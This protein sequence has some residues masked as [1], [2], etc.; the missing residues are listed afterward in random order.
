[1]NDVY[2]VKNIIPYSLFYRKDFSLDMF[3]HHSEWKLLKEL[4]I[5]KIP[6]NY[7]W[8]ATE[9]HNEDT[10]EYRLTVGIKKLSEDDLLDKL[11]EDW[12]KE[13][14][15]RESLR[16]ESICIWDAIQESILKERAEYHKN[17]KEEE[18]E[19]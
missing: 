17:R 18:D 11:G 6:Y 13:L 19:R 7:E 12:D 4:R 3:Y 10:M 15:R 8:C 16:R 9:E 2:Y 1:M 14:E 5:E